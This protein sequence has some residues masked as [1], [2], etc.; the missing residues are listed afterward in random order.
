[1]SGHDE[2]S[3][4]MKSFSAHLNQYPQKAK[5][6]SI[7]FAILNPSLAEINQSYIAGKVYALKV[8]K[9]SLH[10]LTLYKILSNDEKSL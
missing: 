3:A 6:C 1:M 4:N 9:V 2:I 10:L 8:Y 7:K 5:I